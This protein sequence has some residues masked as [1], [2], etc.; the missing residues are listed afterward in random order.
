MRMVRRIMR[1]RYG[2]LRNIRVAP[3]AAQS[4]SGVLLEG[5]TL[6]FGTARSR[7]L[8]CRG[9]ATS[10]ENTN[11]YSSCIWRPALITKP[12]CIA[13]R[14]RWIAMHCVAGLGRMLTAIQ[15]RIAMQKSRAG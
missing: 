9:S 10:S 5:R 7:A 11:S 12:T 1:H 15:A 8:A 2:R 3:R 6:S 4:S 13:L 14:C